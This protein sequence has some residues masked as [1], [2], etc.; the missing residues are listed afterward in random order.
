MKNPRTRKNLFQQYL[1]ASTECHF[2]STV[3]DQSVT[4]LAT[5]VLARSYSYMSRMQKEDMIQLRD[6]NFLDTTLFAGNITYPIPK[7]DSSRRNSHRRES[8]DALASLAKKVVEDFSS[9]KTSSN[10]SYSKKSSKKS[11]KKFTHASGSVN[12]TT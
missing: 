9:M 7:I 4:S 10:S 6:A 2:L 11:F 5:T 1:Q 8:V 3:V 12:T